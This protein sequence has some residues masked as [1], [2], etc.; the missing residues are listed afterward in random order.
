MI[1]PRAACGA[2]VLVLGGAAA[3][4]A[5]PGCRGEA[6]SPGAGTGAS[7]ASGAAGSAGSPGSG[8]DKLTWPAIDETA[9]AALQTTERF[10]LGTPEPLAITPDGAVLFRRSKPRSRVADLYQLDAAGKITQLANAAALIA[11]P[12]PAPPGAPP[13]RGS[14]AEP[15]APPARRISAPA[16]RRSAS[17][18]T[19][20]A[21]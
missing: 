10:A 3:L 21:C 17:R 6:R 7:A 11:A 12:P 9:L 19:A 1:A 20:P 15:P 8:D 5:A 2:L 13:A 4:V 14:A 16:S 18:T